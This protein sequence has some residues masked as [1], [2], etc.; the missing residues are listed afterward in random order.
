MFGAIAVL[1]LLPWLDTSKV[2]SARYRPVFKW[3]FWALVICVFVLGYVGGKPAEGI[4]IPIG[5]VATAYYFVHFLIIL[6]LLGRLERPK[7]LPASIG[8]SVL[9]GGGTLLGATTTRTGTVIT[10]HSEAR[11]EV[12][13]LGAISKRK[14]IRPVPSTGAVP[15]FP[16]CRTPSRCSAR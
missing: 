14:A 7:P 5:Q 13:V 4:W 6:P 10:V 15:G 8:K 12:S 9:H 3:F 2:R 11:R 1:A 16:C